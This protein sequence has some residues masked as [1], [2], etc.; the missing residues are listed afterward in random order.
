MKSK[1]KVL[2][3]LLAA[4]ILLLVPVSA[5]L[6]DPKYGLIK[7]NRRKHIVR[8]WLYDSSYPGGFDPQNPPSYRDL[9]VSGSV[10]FACQS[11][12]GFQY[13]VAV[14]G[15]ASG[16]TYDVR[17][18]SLATAFLPEP[19]AGADQP[20]SDGGGNTYPL[21][22]ITTNGQGEGEVTGLVPLPATHYFLPFGW[23]GWEIKVADAGE[24]VLW[25]IPEDPIDFVVFPEWP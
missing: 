3:A 23:Y 15:L 2:L 24:D 7:A 12:E 25:T 1:R 4:L 20:T 21:G 18:V 9:G 17:A 14:K 10:T 16:T 22:T 19:P 6:A 8:N 5:V 11:V 13:S